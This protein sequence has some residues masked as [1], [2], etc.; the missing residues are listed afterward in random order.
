M[1]L[2]LEEKGT[3]CGEQCLYASFGQFGKREIEDLLRMYNFLF[4]G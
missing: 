4:K 2:L 3:K 1:T